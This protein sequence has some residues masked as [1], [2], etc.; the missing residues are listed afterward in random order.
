[1]AVTTKS[2][3]STPLRYRYSDGG[4]KKAGFKGYTGDCLARAIAILPLRQNG[5]SSRKA[6]SSIALEAC[7]LAATI[8]IAISEWRTG[9]RFG[10]DGHRRLPAN[11]PEF[12]FPES[13]R[14]L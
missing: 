2:K 12:A 5:Y 6:I 1:M 14:V 7:F 4:R 8:G 10:R 3:S 11:N 9:L 13:Q